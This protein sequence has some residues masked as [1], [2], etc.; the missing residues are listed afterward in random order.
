MVSKK[1]AIGARPLKAKTVERFVNNGGDTS[2]KRLTLDI[3]SDLHSRIKVT[4]AVRGVTMVAAI[5]EM[6]NERFTA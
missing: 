4:C 5:L 6:L 1:V 3:P 2:K